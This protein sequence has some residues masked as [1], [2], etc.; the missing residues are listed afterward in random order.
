MNWTL[1]LQIYVLES[2]NGLYLYL[3]PNLCT[4][5]L[6]H[7][8]MTSLGILFVPPADVFL[9]TSRSLK[10]FLRPI[11]PYVN[12]VFLIMLTSLSTFRVASTSSIKIVFSSTSLGSLKTIKFFYVVHVMLDFPRTVCLPNHS[13]ISDGLDLS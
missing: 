1:S 7:I 4:K 11:I 3:M 8:P 13:L 10:L 6:L 9:T 5:N 12:W 2:R